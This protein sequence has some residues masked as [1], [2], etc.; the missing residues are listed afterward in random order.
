[1]SKSLAG[2]ELLKDG[3]LPG[4]ATYNQVARAIQ[5]C[6]SASPNLDIRLKAD[7]GMEFEIKD[8]SRQTTSI[9]LEASV[10]YDNYRKPYWHVN[11][12][13]IRCPNFTYEIEETSVLDFGA[14][15]YLK[16]FHANS[17]DQPV[18]LYSSNS[19]EDDLN[20]SAMAAK[21]DYVVIPL[22]SYDEDTRKVTILHH[23]DVIWPHTPFNLLPSFV[24]GYKWALIM[25]PD[26]TEDC[27]L[28]EDCVEE[29]GVD[30]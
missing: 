13:A 30:G 29:V 19:L 25:N 4:A 20:G 23:G 2:I 16:V 8:L 28:I 6:S 22:A 17:V 24:A 27:M 26:N 15:V 10:I 11:A 12:G 21:K 5:R 14:Y 3:C 18:Q 9:A 7:G 1:M